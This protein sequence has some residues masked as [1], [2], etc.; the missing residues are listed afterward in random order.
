MMLRELFRGINRIGREFGVFQIEISTYSSLESQVHLRAAFPE[1]WIFQKMSLETFQKI[2]RHFPL[3]Q[4]VSIRGWGEPL[5]NEN[6]IPMLHLAKQAHCLTGLTTNGMNLTENLAQQI[7]QEALDLIVISLEIENQPIQESLQEDS[8][9]KHIMEQVEELVQI[10]KK[11]RRDKPFVKLS[12]PMTRLNMR[13][14]PNVVPLAARLG[15]EEVIFTH[16]DYLLR[17][18]S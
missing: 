4:W 15:V 14:L 2:S 17:L 3:A 9:L 11:L 10:K 6:I 8:N 12:F 18:S 1:Q 13:E 16:L 7:L 5:E